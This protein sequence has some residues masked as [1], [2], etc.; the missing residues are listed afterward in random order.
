MP[1]YTREHRPC[2][3]V[4]KI[5]P[6][7]DIRVHGP[8]IRV[9]FTDP[10]AWS[11]LPVFTG[12]VHGPRRR[13][14]NRASFL[15]THEH[16]PSRSPGAVVNGVI[17]IFQYVAGRVSKMTPVFTGPCLR[18]VNTGSVQVLVESSTYAYV[19]FVCRIDVH[20]KESTGLMEKVTQSAPSHQFCQPFGIGHHHHSEA[21]VVRLLLT[22]FTII[23]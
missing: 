21:C 14:V 6:I 8:W 7:F 16:G 17:V 10:Y 11:T 3:R 1:V 15:D 18:P 5:T 20:S 2:T 19:R 12:R 23:G 22:R 4:S 9:V 13:P